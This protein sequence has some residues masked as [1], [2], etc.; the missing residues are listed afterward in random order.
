MGE[1]LEA[2]DRG[3][4]GSLAESR[5]AE[6]FKE[7][8]EARSGGGERHNNGLIARVHRDLAV[9][10][11]D[12][13]RVR[14]LDWKEPEFRRSVIQPSCKGAPKIEQEATPYEYVSIEVEGYAAVQ[15]ECPDRP[16]RPF[17]LPA[18]KVAAN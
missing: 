16:I 4:P 11:L 5:I 8:T 7:G 2:C 6:L 18:S 10:H 3:E 17:S 9:D 15:S 1:P 13:D 14:L 12:D